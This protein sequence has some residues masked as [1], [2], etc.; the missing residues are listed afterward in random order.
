MDGVDIAEM[1]WK[2]G[3]SPRRQYHYIVGPRLAALR[4]EKWKLHLKPEPP[5]KFAAAA[6]YDLD[7][8]PAERRDLAAEKP[9][10]VRELAEQA[11]AFL[12][13]WNPAPPCPP[14]PEQYRQRGGSA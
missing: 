12:S 2:E 6:L 5:G 8:D 13:A 1:F 10:V 3:S 4:H 11:R 14:P 9:A 7:A